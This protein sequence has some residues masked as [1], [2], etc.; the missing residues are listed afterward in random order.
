MQVEKGLST[1]FPYVVV[2]GLA[3]A[4]AYVTFYAVSVAITTKQNLWNMGTTFVR[5]QF[6]LFPTEEGDTN[7][8]AR[9]MMTDYLAPY[10]I[11]LI[12]NFPLM[13]E[14]EEDL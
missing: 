13:Y 14:G 6:P 2:L 10:I 11:P 7:K 3:A 12:E 4:I 5:E 8:F 9:R 1:A